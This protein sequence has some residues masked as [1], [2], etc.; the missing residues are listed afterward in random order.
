V[1]GIVQEASAL[2]CL[3]SVPGIF[4]HV[5]AI[6]ARKRYRHDV[7]AWMK[8]MDVILHPLTKPE[9]FGRV[10]IEGMAA[11]GGLTEVVR[12]GSNG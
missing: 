4:R 11:A 8:A 7:P 6:T 10:I 2:N 3:R 12:H 1:S 9:P 5:H